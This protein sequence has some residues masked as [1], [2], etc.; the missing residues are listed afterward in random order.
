MLGFCNAV[1]YAW[2]RRVLDRSAY[3]D[4]Y[5]RIV[6]LLLTEHYPITNELFNNPSGYV[7]VYVR[8]LRSEMERAGWD[9]E[10]S[11]HALREA[12]RPNTALQP[13]GS[14]GG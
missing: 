2:R 13:T 14:A 5:Y 10:K 12:P 6:K 8:E 11:H 4:H 9:F 1:A 7:S 3:E